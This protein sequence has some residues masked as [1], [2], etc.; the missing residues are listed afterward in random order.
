MQKTTLRLRLICS[1][2]F[3]LCRV[4]KGRKEKGSR[5]MR[6]IWYA[7]LIIAQHFVAMVC[8]GAHSK[9]QKYRR[10]TSIFV[11]V[12]FLI[13]FSSNASPSGASSCLTFPDLVYVVSSFIIIPY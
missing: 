12:R 13:S 5:K 3:W 9:T 11:D 7:V 1:G 4:W 8:M 10:N 6:N 2:T